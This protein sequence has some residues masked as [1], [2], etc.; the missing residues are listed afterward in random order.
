MFLSSC[1]KTLKG[2]FHLS[3]GC[4]QSVKT[5]TSHSDCAHEHCLSPILPVHC[6]SGVCQCAPCM[7]NSDCPLPCPFPL[8]G[9][10][11]KGNCT[12]HASISKR[13]A[14]AMQGKDHKRCSANTDCVLP[15]PDMEIS[16]CHDG[17]CG[18][19]APC[20]DDRDCIIPCPAG[21]V[22]YCTADGSCQCHAAC[23]SD[24]ECRLPCPMGMVGF[25]DAGNCH[26]HVP[27]S[28]S[29]N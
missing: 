21:M 27:P 25:C 16:S 29:R 10:C 15:C 19:H 13:N 26:C 4:S 11:D 12:C 5:C 2:E 18:C 6:D 3:T 23:K 1:K 8:L 7:S 9:Y 17:T 28:T 14:P 24:D 22:G 20:R